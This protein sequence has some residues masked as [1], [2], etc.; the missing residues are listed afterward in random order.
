MTK[1]VNGFFL[2]IAICFL[3]LSTIVPIIDF[4]ITKEKLLDK[5]QFTNVDDYVMASEN[6][7]SQIGLHVSGTK[8]F[9]GYF[10]EVWAQPNGKSIMLNAVDKLIDGG[11]NE[12][13][14]WI[15][16]AGT[17]EIMFLFYIFDKILWL[18][19]AYCIF[20]IPISMV[21]IFSKA[22]RKGVE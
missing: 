13:I 9:Y 18:F 6:M 11:F 17:N 2:I 8:E 19:V 7:A 5:G 10:N 3:I 22:I 4:F 14:S 20:V 12:V 1:K 15:S 21:D 16:Y